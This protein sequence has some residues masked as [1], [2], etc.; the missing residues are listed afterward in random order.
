M[1]YYRFMMYGDDHQRAE[2]L[3]S[4]DLRDDAAAQ[5]F[6][7]GV[8]RDLMQT[9]AGSYFGWTMDITAVNRAV[10]SIPFR[11]FG[12]ALGTPLGWRLSYVACRAQSTMARSKD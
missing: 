1:G 10:V 6:G 8:I 12:A 2:D 9:R 3:G 11:R 5:S 4:M 7:Y